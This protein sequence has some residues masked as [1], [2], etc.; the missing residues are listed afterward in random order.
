MPKFIKSGLAP[1]LFCLAGGVCHTAVD[2][3]EVTFVVRD[4]APSGRPSRQWYFPTFRISLR[5]L[6]VLFT[7]SC[8]VCGWVGRCLSLGYRR[9][10]AVEQLQASAYDVINEPET[11]VSRWAFWWM[12]PAYRENVK[13]VHLPANG[14]TPECISALAS[15]P[16]CNR[17][18]ISGEFDS[19]QS[20]AP[21]MQLDR[22]PHPVCLELYFPI[23][24]YTPTAEC[25]ANCLPFSRLKEL[26]L[27]GDGIGDTHVAILAAA[28]SLQH[29]DLKVTCCTPAGL[30]RLALRTPVL[31]SLRVTGSSEMVRAAAQFPMLESLDISSWG[32]GFVD[33]EPLKGSTR[34]RAL[35]I[36][37]FGMANASCPSI[38]RLPLLESLSICETNISDAGIASITQA[39]Q[40]TELRVY[41]TPIS[42]RGLAELPRLANLKVLSLNFDP[43]KVSDV[44]AMHLGN[45]LSLEELSLS[46][47]DLSDMGLEHLAQLPKLR[48]LHVSGKFTDAGLLPL[49]QQRSLRELNLEG[50]YLSDGAADTLSQASQLTKLDVTSSQISF[51]KLTWLRKQLPQCEVSVTRFRCGNQ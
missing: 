7:V 17:L 13:E 40:L 35:R 39:K 37:G 16:A 11:T 43:R 38:A 44:A 32:R 21:L 19:E 28:E 5:T 45:C 25:L 27:F 51:T 23:T 3:S 46:N 10:R 9:A 1:P 24:G 2:P 50:Y 14:L 6:F 48:K 12:P 18:N 36:S 42:D 41:S 4:A 20:L 8:L 26:R 47:T 49:V 30:E 22:M 34:L 15:L 31:N 33:F 29:L